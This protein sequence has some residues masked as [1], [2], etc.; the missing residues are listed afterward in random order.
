MEANEISQLIA[1]CNLS[2]D[3]KLSWHLTGN[4]YPPIDEEFIPIAKVAIDLANSGEWDTLIE[5]PNGIQRTVGFTV[6]GM[7]LE[8]FLENQQ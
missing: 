5:Y 6:E 7:H 4:H 8:Y 3:E 2:L 1:D